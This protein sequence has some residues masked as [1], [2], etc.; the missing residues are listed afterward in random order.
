MGA[1]PSAALFMTARTARP[2]GE[3]RGAVS[4]PGDHKNSPTS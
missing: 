4:L 3:T 2:S 1:G